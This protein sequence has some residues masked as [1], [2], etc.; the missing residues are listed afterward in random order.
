MKNEDTN[1]IILRWNSTELSHRLILKF[2]T[3]IYARK[4]S[5]R[6]VVYLGQTFSFI[7]SVT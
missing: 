2:I 6:Y 1:D 4:L 3:C 5:Y 7:A